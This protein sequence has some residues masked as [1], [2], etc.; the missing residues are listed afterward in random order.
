MSVVRLVAPVAILVAVLVPTGANTAS[1]ATISCGATISANTTLTHNLTCPDGNG[2]TLTAGVTLNL[3]GHR[4][5]G[6]GADTSGAAGRTAVTLPLDGSATVVNGSITNWTIGIG[7]N[8]DLDGQP[9]A[10]IRNVRLINNG[11]AVS[12]F[13]ATVRVERATIAGSLFN[14]VTAFWFS[15]VTVTHSVL[16]DNHQAVSSGTAQ[17]SLTRS[18]LVDNENGLACSEST[19]TMTDSRVSG[20]TRALDSFNGSMVLNHNTIADNTTGYRTSFETQD[21]VTGN[22]FTRNDIAVSI[23][24]LAQAG[25][26]GNTFIANRIGY[27]LGHD[28]VE[29]YQVELTGNTFSRNGD[30]IYATNPGTSIGSNTARRNTRWGIY[31]P[32]ATDL[33][34]NIARGNGNQPQCVGVV[35]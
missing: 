2:L 21:V 5:K 11:T 3:G 17:V 9:G 22:R 30:G 27:T 15:D 19:C 10:L 24:S 12:A 16:R 32:G 14:G 7:G 4:L 18:T 13:R 6:P 8:D 26:R 31:A 34:G 20:S 23:G 1:A 28:E 25:I 29:Q 33:G 35:C